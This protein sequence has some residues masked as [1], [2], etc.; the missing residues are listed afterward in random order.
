MD[1]SQ[2][3]NTFIEESH[4]LLVQMESI[5]LSVEQRG[6]SEEELNALFRCAHTIKGSAGLF[7]FNELLFTSNNVLFSLASFTILS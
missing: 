2:A 1:L 7:G 6:A 4:D 5:L 3:L